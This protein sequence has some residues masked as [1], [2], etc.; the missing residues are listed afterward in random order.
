MIELIFIEV[1]NIIEECNYNNKTV[2]YFI[3]KDNDFLKVDLNT[4]G[5]AWMRN[6]IIKNVMINILNIY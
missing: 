5:S 4:F 3:A 1:K 2:S 6:I